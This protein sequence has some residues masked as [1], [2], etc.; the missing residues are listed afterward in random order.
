MW[1]WQVKEKNAHFLGNTNSGDQN[2]L[3]P[4]IYHKDTSHYMVLKKIG[5][6]PYTPFALSFI[7]APV[8]TFC[9]KIE[10]TYILKKSKQTA[11]I[12]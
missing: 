1:K 3:N 6:A 8:K 10:S 11:E 4:F 2:F 5:V 9:L 7:N 12:S